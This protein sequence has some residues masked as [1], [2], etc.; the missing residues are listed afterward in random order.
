MS[1]AGLDQVWK[2]RPR[3][4]SCRT[5]ERICFEEGGGEC[6]LERGLLLSLGGEK[7][8]KSKRSAEIE[9]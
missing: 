4:S 5:L 7:A 8:R 1:E 2:E 6:N 9:G 3:S